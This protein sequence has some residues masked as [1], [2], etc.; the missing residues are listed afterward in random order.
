MSVYGKAQLRRHRGSRVC[1]ARVAQQQLWDDGFVAIDTNWK[2]TFK[3]WGAPIVEAQM[4]VRVNKRENRVLKAVYVPALWVGAA[5]LFAQSR[6]SVSGRLRG[7]G[8]IARFTGYAEDCS[9]LTKVPDAQ[10]ME[11]VIAEGLLKGTLSQDPTFLY[12]NNTTAFLR[13]GQSDFDRKRVQKVLWNLAA[14]PTII[15]TRLP[16]KRRK[17]TQ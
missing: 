4:V 6:L 1:D 10:E 17:K 15:N 5:S 16:K 7:S 14:T 2:H 8:A 9:Y 11:R 13:A 3:Q 12:D